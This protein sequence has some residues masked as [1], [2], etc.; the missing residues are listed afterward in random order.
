MYKFDTLLVVVLLKFMVYNCIFIAQMS[1]FKYYNLSQ[2]RDDVNAIGCSAMLD[3]Y[4]SYTVKV[5]VCMIN[6]LSRCKSQKKI[7][8]LIIVY[9]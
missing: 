7:T 8:V 9:I 4:D 2:V 1:F 5:G 6:H 3:K